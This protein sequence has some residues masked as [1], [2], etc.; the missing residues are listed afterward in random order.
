MRR[1]HGLIVDDLNRLSIRLKLENS[2]IRA[3][4]F[5]Q[6]QQGVLDVT[7]GVRVLAQGNAVLDTQL[8]ARPA[9]S[10]SKVPNRVSALMVTRRRPTL[11]MRAIRCFLAQS[12]KVSELVVIDDS[13]DDALA[14]VMHAE[15]SGDARRR[16]IYERLP[17]SSTTLGELRNH[18]VHRATGSLVCQW[19]DDD[20]Y[21]PE[22]IAT[23][24]AVLCG[25]SADACSLWRHQILWQVER[26]LCY[27]V[28]RVWE[29]SLLCR[30][31]LLPLYP[32]ERRGEDTPVVETL[33]GRG[34]FALIDEP[35]LYTYIVHGR[36]TFDQ[37]HFARHWL[38]ATERF[39]GAQF[40]SEVRK[41]ARTLPP[42]V[43]IEFLE[44]VLGPEHAAAHHAG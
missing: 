33:L 28:R 32:S 1:F 35:W 2:A 7:V 42:P 8:S 39:E 37:A 5:H 13:E 17:P 10:A 6:A 22:R 16:I 31:D 29:G 30:K 43:A 34:R 26:R 11:A 19:D 3:Q 4:Y 38:R 41:I 15:I 21:H 20:L 40:E 24:V 23:Q 12:Y 18:A 27:S 44:A 36:N 14:R 25:T 9:F